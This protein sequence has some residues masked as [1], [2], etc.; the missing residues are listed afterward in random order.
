MRCVITILAA[1]LL[2]PGCVSTGVVPMDHDTYMISK[3]SAQIGLG[4]PNGAKAD[5]Y[6]E[7]NQYCRSQ[8]KVVETVALD[9]TNSAPAQ[10]AAASLQFRCVSEAIPK[11][12]S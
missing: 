2:A 1:T 6:R 4:P 10:P 5:I 12:T 8:G 9:L 7:A 3:R 11:P